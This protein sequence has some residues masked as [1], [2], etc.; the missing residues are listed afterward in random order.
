MMSLV[1]TALEV[2]NRFGAL[3]G[4]SGTQYLILNAIARLGTRQPDLGI[5]ALAGYLRLSGTF[6]TNE[7]NRL[8]AAGLATKAVNPKD[9]RRVVL[10][11]TDEAVRR[12]AELTRIQSPANDT[13]FDLTAYEF[14]MLRTLLARLAAGGDRTLLL[15]EHLAPDGTLDSLR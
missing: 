14:R 6:V 13:F 9:R 1:S 4:V 5:N 2:R 12:L 15:I 10:G 11:V 3:I 8:V 7:V